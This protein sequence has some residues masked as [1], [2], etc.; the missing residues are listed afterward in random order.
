MILRLVFVN[1]V[2]LLP[3]LLLFVYVIGERS[4]RRERIWLFMSPLALAMI[5]RRVMVINEL[6]DLPV[7]KGHAVILAAVPNSFSGVARSPRTTCSHRED[8]TFS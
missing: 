7:V 2:G 4:R 5:D 8:I 6:S 3:L 1:G